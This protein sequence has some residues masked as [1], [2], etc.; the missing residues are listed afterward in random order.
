MTIKT[1]SGATQA[2]ADLCNVLDPPSKGCHA[3]G[4]IHVTIPP[5]WQA[6]IAAGQDVP[7]CSYYRVA[8]N[9][10]I[11]IADQVPMQLAIPAVI[12]AL[13]PPQQAEAATLTTKLSVA[14][15]TAQ[16]EVEP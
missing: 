7:G 8:E 1:I 12:A 3:G 14:V 10:T 4:G 6:R 2:D 9:G 5:D 11:A 13:T 16:M 15:V